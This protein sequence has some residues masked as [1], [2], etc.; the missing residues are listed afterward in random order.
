[1]FCYT[2]W[3]FY[4][5]SET[6]LLTRRHSASSLFSAVLCFRKATQEIF[7]ELDKI[8]VEPP[9]FIEASRRLK[10]RRRGATGRPHPRV[11]QPWPWPRHQGVRPLGPPPDAAI[12]PIYSPR[13]EK[14]KPDQFSTK[15]TASRRRRRRE[16]GRLQKLFP[17]PYRR[18]ESPP[19]DFFIT[20]VTSG[21]MCEL[22]TLDYGS[23]AVAR[24]SSPP[25]YASCLD[26]VS[27]PTWSIS[28]LCNSTCCV[29]WDP[30]SIGTMSSW[31]AELLS[32]CYLYVVY[33]LACSPL[34]VDI[35]AE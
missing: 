35:L 27:C 31:Y 19:E 3:Y 20:M 33:D 11:E 15:P 1:V 32:L 10:M 14:P 4:A 24:W 30:M 6:N 8:K 25:P 16:I 34:L 17:A 5:F 12:P 7:S 9:I 26:L 13:L 22:S 23:I 28:S 21:A 18:G 29:C 2:S